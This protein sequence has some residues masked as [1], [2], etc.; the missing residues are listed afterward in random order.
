MMIFQTV[1]SSILI[2]E[3]HKK[4]CVISQALYVGSLVVSLILSFFIKEDLKRQDAEKL[5]KL[6]REQNVTNDLRQ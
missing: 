6:T 4:G 1:I 5:K 2:S 3:Y